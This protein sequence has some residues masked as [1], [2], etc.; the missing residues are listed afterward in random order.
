MA[1]TKKAKTTKV[2]T[3]TTQAQMDKAIYGICNILRRDKCKGARLYVPELTWMLFLKAID[4]AEEQQERKAAILD[5]DTKFAASIASPYRWRDWVLGEKRQELQKG[6]MGS[7]LKFVNNEL[8]PYL[9]SLDD[10]EKNPGA[11]DQQ[12]I[13]AEIFRNKEKTIIASETNLLEALDEVEEL[14]Q[15]KLSD[16]HMFPIS[17]GFEGLLPRMG[18]KKNDGGQFFTPREIIRVIVKAVNPKLDKTVYD[19]ACG[20]GG[21]LIEAFK[22]MMAQKPTATQIKAL[23]TQTLWGREDATEAIPICLANMVLHGIDLP[24]IWHGNTLTGIAT[25]GALFEG[26]PTQFDYIFTNPPFGGKE[27]EAAQVNFKYKCNKTQILFMQHIID[28]MVDVLKDGGTCGMVVDEGVLF[29]TKTDAFT[30]TKRKLLNECNLWCIVSLPAGVFVN[31]GANVKTDLLFF[32]KGQHTEKIWFYDMTLTEDLEDRKVGKKTPL[33]AEHFD[34]FFARL[35]LDP[36]DPGRESD[37][38]WTVDFAQRKR[39]AKAKSDPLKREAGVLNEKIKHYRETLK[40]LKN[41]KQQ[42]TE[43]YQAIEETIRELDKEVRELLAKAKAIDDAVYNLKATN[44]NAPD[45]TDKRTPEELMAI[46]KDCQ[47]EIAAGL[48]ALRAI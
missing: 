10:S 48:E 2:R 18:D 15:A 23:K 20:T 27:G 28:A 25:Y 6:A 22:H 1:S 16:K 3:I 24:R 40:E 42:D 46:I 38:S 29:H 9:R 36:T 17:Q 12:R 8:F 4:V 32:T 31:A 19:P 7:V 41:T 44:P 43:E 5:P 33:L 37:R 21:F 26:A 39:E 13:I 30:Q 34:D 14:S 11:T 47:Q 45:R 35:A